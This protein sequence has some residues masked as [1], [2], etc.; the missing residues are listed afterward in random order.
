MLQLVNMGK[1]QTNAQR[2]MSLIAEWLMTLPAHWIKT[3]HVKVGEQLLSYRGV[4]LTPLQAQRFSQWSTWADARIVT[5]REV[6]IVEG[7]LVATGGAYGQV[8]DYVN[9]YPLSA[10][11][12]LWP[13]RE[14]VPVVVAQAVRPRTQAYFA[15]M[16][17][18]T[19]LFSPSFD[20]AQ[21]LQKLFQSAEILTSPT[22]G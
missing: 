1:P 12:K 9:D 10:D 8:L 4:A 13:N 6:W 22:T 7:K 11:A 2:E 3:T 20:L 14:I 18:R 16:G 15:T 17:V 21:S 19:I 5:P